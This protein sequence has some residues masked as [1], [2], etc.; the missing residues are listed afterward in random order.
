MKCIVGTPHLSERIDYVVDRVEA[1]HRVLPEMDVRP[2][3]RR[4]LEEVWAAEEVARRLEGHR[5]DCLESPIRHRRPRR[6]LQ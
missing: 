2:D 4:R 5:L 6:Q 3:I 1:I